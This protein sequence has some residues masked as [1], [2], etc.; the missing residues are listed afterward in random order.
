MVAKAVPENVIISDA[1]V[2]INFLEIG[3]FRILLK[4]FKG[5]LHITN[6][7]RGEIRRNREEL[8]EAITDGEINEHKIPLNKSTTLRRA[9]Q[10]SM[11]GKLHVSCWERRRAGGLPP[12]MVR[13]KNSCA[14]SLAACTS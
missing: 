14:R 12:M 6:V 2:L 7:V 3:K 4:T 10:A 13:R 9:L 5:R 8:D 1:T 11:R